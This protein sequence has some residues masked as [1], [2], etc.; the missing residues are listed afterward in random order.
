MN[1]E[2]A[3]ITRYFCY[4]HLLLLLLTALFIPCAQELALKYAPVTGF[5]VEDV[6]SSLETIRS[7]T[8]R[9]DEGNKQFKETSV[10]TLELHL[11]REE[12]E[13]LHAFR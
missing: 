5:T 9:K 8:S 2:A 7:D 13:V 6:M 3:A 10:A 1:E 4:N 11:P 12:G